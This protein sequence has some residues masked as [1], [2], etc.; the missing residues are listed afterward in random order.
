MTS[1]EG[2]AVHE[3]IHRSEDRVGIGIEV[4]RLR[5]RVSCAEG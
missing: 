5:D 1:E 3:L 2:E 4:V